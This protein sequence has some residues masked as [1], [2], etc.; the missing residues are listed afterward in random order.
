[1]SENNENLAPEQGETEET[2]KDKISKNHAAAME[3]VK[4]LVGGEQQLIPRKQLS[5]DSTARV[6]A[7]LFHEEQEE[8]EKKA[9]DQLRDLLK[10]YFVF[11][12]EVAKSEKELEQKKLAKKKEFTEAVNNVKRTFSEKIVRD[13]GYAAA[14][15]A[16]TQEVAEEKK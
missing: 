13:D 11:T 2:K 6:V 14:L 1:M 8:F 4:A 12:E 15:K 10:K 3:F 7:L 9:L 16:A 5:E